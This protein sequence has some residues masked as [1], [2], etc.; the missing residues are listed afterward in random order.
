MGTISGTLKP[1]LK[2][3]PTLRDLRIRWD[4]HADSADT[5][6]TVL[7]GMPCRLE[8]LYIGTYG[9][10]I[11]RPFATLLLPWLFDLVHFRKSH[12]GPLVAALIL[13]HFQNLRTYRQMEE[14]TSI[15]P[16][17]QSFSAV[18][19]MG[20]LLENC[21]HLTEFDG[22]NHQIEADYLLAH[23]WVCKGLEVL[24]CQIVGVHRLSE[25]EEIDYRQAL[26]FLRVKKRSL[27]QEERL[28]MEKH[29]RLRFQQQLVYERLSEMANLKVLDLGKEYRHADDFRGA[30]TVRNGVNEYSASTGPIPNTLELSMVSGLGQLSTLKK[31]EVFGFEGVDHRIE[32]R[33]LRW[34]ASSWPRLKVMRG[35]HSVKL[36]RV[37]SRPDDET[38]Y[39]RRY[40]QKLRPRVKHEK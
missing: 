24:R 7:G 1:L 30:M 13:A 32:E 14:T 37:K 15:H 34:M 38:T 21:P 2:K 16:S 11:D 3:L 10:W 4:A 36:T 9:S 18:N 8:R 28:A 25:E 31:L 17:Y 39:L 5:L 12:L 27:S 35:L 20:L 33:E 26:L 6:G 22:I 19:T 29:E 40:M 23:L